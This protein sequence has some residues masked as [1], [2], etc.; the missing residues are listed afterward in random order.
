MGN[1][2]SIMPLYM[3]KKLFPRATIRQLV[4]TRDTNTK[5]KMYKQTTI[6]QL[7]ICRVKIEHNNKHKMYNFF[8]VPGNGQALLGMPDTEILNVLTICCKTIHTMEADKG[9]HCRI[10]RPVMHGVG[11]CK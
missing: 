11:L 10:N 2:G 4:A 6:M 7:G 8:V 9:A 5:L 1:D 3:Y